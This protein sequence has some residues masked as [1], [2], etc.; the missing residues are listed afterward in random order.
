MEP[1]GVDTRDGGES[2]EVEP[3]PDE[4]FGSSCDSLDG[5]RVSLTIL[6]VFAVLADRLALASL[7]DLAAATRVVV[8]DDMSGRSTVCRNEF[9][10]LMKFRPRQEEMRPLGLPRVSW[11]SRQNHPLGWLS[12]VPRERE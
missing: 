3:D 7:V 12:F 5:D 10:R 6:L 9:E 1:L 4:A 11:R 2:D 8:V